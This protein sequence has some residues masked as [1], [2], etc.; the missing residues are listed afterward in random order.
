MPEFPS[1]PACP[2]AGQ[3]TATRQR[4]TRFTT[5]SQSNNCGHPMLKGRRNADNANADFLHHT[6]GGINFPTEMGPPPMV[7]QLVTVQ[8]TLRMTTGMLRVPLKSLSFNYISRN[9][10]SKVSARKTRETSGHSF[11]HAWHSISGMSKPAIVILN[12]SV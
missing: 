1:P 7:S 3:S 5:A 8:K 12:T 11:V 10:N 2:S 9:L 6:L 4:L